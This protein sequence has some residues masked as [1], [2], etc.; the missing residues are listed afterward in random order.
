MA[1]LQN[2]LGDDT[3]WY[4]R[5][6]LAQVMQNLSVNLVVSLGHSYV[7]GSGLLVLFG[8]L[9]LQSWQQTAITLSIFWTRT[10]RERERDRKQDVIRGTLKQNKKFVP[11]IKTKTLYKSEGNCAGGEKV[12]SDL[13]EELRI[14][15]ERDNYK[16]KH[17]MECFKKS[18][19]FHTSI[20]GNTMFGERRPLPK[21]IER[22]LDKHSVCQQA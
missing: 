2:T 14:S 10:K 12:L 16:L 22:R 13:I 4:L 9:G 19:I 7:A 1:H 21:R 11:D 3:L 17:Q 6:L 18:D 15:K 8:A 20:R 5:E